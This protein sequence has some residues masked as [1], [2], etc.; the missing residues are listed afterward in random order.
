[1]R[2]THFTHTPLKL[3]RVTVSHYILEHGKFSSIKVFFNKFK[4]VVFVSNFDIIVKIVNK[5]LGNK[6]F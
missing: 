1:M 4:L 5:M 2:V 6:I 3:H